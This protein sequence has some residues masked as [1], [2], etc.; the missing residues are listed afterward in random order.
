MDALERP[1]LLPNE[2]RACAANFCTERVR[3]GML[4]CR[5][6]WFQ[7]PQYMRSA[8]LN[9]WSARHMQAYGEAVEAAR[10]YLGGFTRVVERV[11]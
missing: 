11:G 4:M 10:D 9:A 8:I 3:R 5:E 6:H 7:L 2:G 1:K